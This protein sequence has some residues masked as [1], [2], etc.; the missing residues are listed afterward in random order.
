MGKGQAQPNKKKFNPYIP[1]SVPGPPS[2]SATVPKK[3]IQKQEPP[4]YSIKCPIMPQSEATQCAQQLQ[5]H[6]ILSKDSN[7]RQG[8]T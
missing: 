7:R 3:R 1:T 2:M 6:G 4:S 8:D 5:D